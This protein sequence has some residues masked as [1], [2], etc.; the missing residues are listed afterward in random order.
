VTLPLFDRP[1]LVE[2]KP[3]PTLRPYQQRAIINLRAQVLF[4]RKRVLAVGPT[5]SGKTVIIA[6]IIRTATLPC[7]FIAHRKE[8]IDQCASQLAAAGITNIGVIR[9]SD[10]RYNPSAA[11]QV[12]SVQT[13]ARRDKPFLDASQV[14]I[15]I[16]EAHRAA[17]D[18]YSNILA[19]YP[20]A[21]VIGFTATPCRLDGKP[22][23]GVFEEIVVV[24]T[25]SELLKNPRWLVAPDCYSSPLK[26]DLSQVH[27]TGADFDEE[28]LAQV[29]HTD[30]LE[31]Q[32]VEHWLRLSNRHPRYT[33][34]GDRIPK[35]FTE[36]ERRRTIVFAVNVAHSKSIAARFERAGVRVAHLDGKTPED[37]RENI[38]KALAEGRLEVV[39]N[40]QVGVEGIDIPEI[41]CVI[42]ARPTYSLTQ[43][44]QAVGRSMR[45]YKGIVPMLLDHGGSFDR[46]GCPFEDMLWTLNRKPLR[47]GSKIPMKLCKQCFAYVEAQKTVCPHCGAEFP[48]NVDP[49]A[50][51]AETHAEL[52]QRLSEPEAL[53]KDFFA[54]QVVTAKSRGFKPG[55]ASAIYKERYGS[56]PPREW[57]DKV[58]AMF[59]ED[60]LWQESL[61]R[62]LERKAKRDAQDKAEEKAL[63]PEK[64]TE[65]QQTL[66][67]MRQQFQEAQMAQA[68]DATLQAMEASEPEEAPFADWVDEQGL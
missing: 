18:S 23:G 46:L 24:T 33:A 21:I 8:I 41:K 35:E 9:G 68:M 59:E 65:T 2:A 27:M 44:R 29:M 36:G 45:P 25:Y 63:E 15:F 57:G 14:L 20:N 48:R 52:V 17:S 4:G 40:C 32:I 3:P 39:T 11:T 22:L 1:T 55:Y 13:L 34:K 54:R 50:V 10:E 5:G 67:S 42:H 62:R 38:L 31:G 53:K 60:V 16:D 26:V 7:L 43:W 12:A 66:E 49:E 64:P 58:K 61:A 47:L 37:E 6:A 19:C 56:W 51:P 28:E 30:R